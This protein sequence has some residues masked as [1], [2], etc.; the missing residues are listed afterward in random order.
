MVV[1]EPRRVWTV[2]EAKAK[3]SEVLRLAETEGPQHIGARKRFVV[4]PAPKDITETWDRPVAVWAQFC[5]EA[6]LRHLG[7]IHEPLTQGGMLL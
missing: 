1:S 2:A 3:L 5:N 4:M 7:T 6:K